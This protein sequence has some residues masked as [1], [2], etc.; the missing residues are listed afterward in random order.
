MG[1]SRIDP[2]P[3][4]KEL[5]SRLS[6]LELGGRRIGKYITQLGVHHPERRANYLHH[7]PLSTPKIHTS[8][9]GKFAQI[10]FHE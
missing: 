6:N 8:Q 5:I 4:I 9:N 2:K 7:E 3:Y 10:H 1:L